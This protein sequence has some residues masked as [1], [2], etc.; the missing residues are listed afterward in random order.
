MCFCVMGTGLRTGNFLSSL[1]V[2]SK[3]EVRSCG[4]TARRQKECNQSKSQRCSHCPLRFHLER[5]DSDAA[6]LRFGRTKCAWKFNHPKHNPKQKTATTLLVGFLLGGPSVRQRDFRTQNGIVLGPRANQDFL[7]RS[8][9][10]SCPEG[11]G[12][13]TQPWR[14]LVLEL[15]WWKR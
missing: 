14:F 5:Y 7:R 13:L 8:H 10:E 9:L 3:Q 12:P 4:T 15:K 1:R 11:R 2:F 6:Y